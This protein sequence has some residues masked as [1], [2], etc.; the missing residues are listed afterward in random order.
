[1]FMEAGFTTGMKKNE[2]CFG[3]NAALYTFSS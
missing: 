2:N 1:M 3:D